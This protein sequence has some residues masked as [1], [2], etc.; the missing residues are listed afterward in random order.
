MTWHF[1]IQV[2]TRVG[3]ILLLFPALVVLGTSYYYRYSGEWRGMTDD[4][5]R[6]KLWEWN[7]RVC[8]PIKPEK[9]FDAIW[10]RIVENHKKPRDEV[11]DA[12]SQINEGGAEDDYLPELEA[13]IPSND[14]SEFV[15]NT[16][17]KTIKQED[18]LVRLRLRP[19]R[20]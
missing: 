3:Y 1:S 5:R 16:A 4:Q 8:H 9:E 7:F 20:L 2:Q 13:N 15:V 6:S 10:N 18:S 19:R 11:H 14:Y 17:K 12:H